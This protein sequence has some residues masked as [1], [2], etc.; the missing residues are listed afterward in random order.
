MLSQVH[1]IGFEIVK[2][3]FALKPTDV[4]PYLTD[5]FH[6][7]ADVVGGSDARFIQYMKISSI[8]FDRF[9]LVHMP[10]DGSVDRA[11]S[12]DKRF[13]PGHMGALLESMYDLMEESKKNLADARLRGDIPELLAKMSIYQTQLNVNQKISDAMPQLAKEDFKARVLEN[14]KDPVHLRG[15]A[16]LVVQN[17]KRTYETFR[18]VNGQFLAFFDLGA[19]H[20]KADIEGHYFNP[21]L[22][23]YSDM[24]RY[25]PVRF[26]NPNFY[27]YHLPCLFN[28]LDLASPPHPGIKRVLNWIFRSQGLRFYRVGES[29]HL[30]D[31]IQDRIKEGDY[32]FYTPKG[33]KYVKVIDLINTQETLF[34]LFQLTAWVHLYYFTRLLSGG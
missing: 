26:N 12:E 20:L 7:I 18:Y 5:S 21:Q 1:D 13:G 29:H 33:P 14:R 16:D 17:I 30:D 10:R 24:Y 19:N 8:F 15:D 28:Y 4:Y 22:N 27:R 6:L 34:R 25:T 9:R 3:I 23:A 32:A 2:G 31:V 11:A